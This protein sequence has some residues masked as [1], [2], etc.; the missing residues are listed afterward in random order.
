MSRSL[1]LA[2]T[3]RCA[4]VA[5]GTRK[6][7][8]ISGV[9]KPAE[10]PQRQGDLGVGRQRRVAA[11]EHQPELVVGDDVDE[12]VEVAEFGWIARET[13]GSESSSR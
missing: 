6:A 5:S 11:E 9:S 13:M 3:I 10:Q 4:I 1:R 8:A 2:R 12:G 7:R